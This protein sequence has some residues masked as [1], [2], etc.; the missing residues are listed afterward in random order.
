MGQCHLNI[1]CLCFSL[2]I[3]A[4]TGA[5]AQ[6][7]QHC[8]KGFCIT[9]T[10]GEIT[11]EAGLCVVI[12]CSFTTPDSFTTQHIVWYKCEPSKQR[13]DS[14]II[15][16]TNKNNINLQTGFKGRVSLLESDLSQKN[17]SIVIND[18]TASDSGSYQLRV[19][20]VQVQ[21]SNGFTFSFRTTTVSVK[22][23]KT[24]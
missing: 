21:K 6:E 23:M 16:H 8:Q 20:G 17:C 18:L 14:D 12:P 19:N 2:P 1:F 3:F 10:E 24:K 9:L 15:F 7:S 5:S 4:I 22:G 11:A 13:C